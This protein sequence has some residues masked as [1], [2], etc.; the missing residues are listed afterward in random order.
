MT[1]ALLPL[2]VL[3]FAFW[4]ALQVV[5]SGSRVL[6]DIVTPHDESHP[7]VVRQPTQC[8]SEAEIA[9]LAILVSLTPG[10]LVLSLGEEDAPETDG[11]A[12]ARVRSLFVHTMYESL[13]EATADVA[14]LE[15]R[16]LRAIRVRGRPE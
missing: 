6:R 3:G 14:R 11:A 12:R 15:R 4:F 7:L 9:L 13:D 5:R 8:R 16:L 1:A 2:R 10:T